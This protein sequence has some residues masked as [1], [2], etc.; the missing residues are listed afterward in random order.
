M[1]DQKRLSNAEIASFCNQTAL[2]FQAGIAPVETLY[3]LLSDVKSE[4]GRELLDA[5][6]TVCRHGEPFHKA[7]ASTNVFPDYVLHTVA[8]GEQAGTL[9]TCML[10]LASYYEKEGAISESIKNAIAY[11]FLMISMMLVVIFVLIS[12]VMPIFN[13]VF[14]E[15]GSEM[16]GFAASLLHLGEN[17]NRYSLIVLLFL[18]F[19]LLIYLVATKT[20]W[21]KINT[22]KFLNV[23]PLTKTFYESVACQRFA[24]GM[25]LCLSSGMDTYTSLDMVFE[26]VGNRRMQEKII[27]CKQALHSGSNLSEALSNSAIFNHLYS[28]MIAV[29]FKSG[30]VDLVLSKIADGYEHTTDKKLQ[31]MISVLE[32]TLVIILSVIVG[33]ILLSVI[34]PLMGIMSSIG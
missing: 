8:L 11:P 15:L 2:L 1:K 7:L 14:I 34:L 23:F 9:D 20:H 26:L 6:L 3:I 28:Q 21:G 32:P 31:S 29:G 19:L 10:A 5:I 30:K 13:Q 27:S 25:A 12:K 17:L 16:T 22:V 24:S 18:C 4:K 33:L